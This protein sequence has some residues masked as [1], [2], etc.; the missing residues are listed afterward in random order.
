[1]THDVEGGLEMCDRV[2]MLQGGHLRFVGSPEDFRTS[3]D[4]VVHAF[5]NRAAA[6][7]ALVEVEVE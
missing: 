5:V 6:A 4:P 1:V 7:A 2:A 3:R